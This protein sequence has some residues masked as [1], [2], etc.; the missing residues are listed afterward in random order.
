MTGRFTL[1][2]DTTG[3][4]VTI[5]RK[6]NGKRDKSWYFHPSYY[7]VDFITSIKQMLG[8]EKRTN[9][10]IV[11]EKFRDSVKDSFNIAKQE[12]DLLNK[13]IEL[14]ENAIKDAIEKNGNI[15]LGEQ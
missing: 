7:H 10:E 2:L 14:A 4:G 11:T 15:E 13:Q 6:C 12:V 9:E 5:I 1:E 3:N 8:L